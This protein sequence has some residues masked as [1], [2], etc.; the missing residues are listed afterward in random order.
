MSDRASF[1]PE[2]IIAA[3]NKAD[4][5]YVV[6]GGF[7]AELHGVP[8]PPTD[9]I[10]FTPAT[11][12]ANLDR[13]AAA[14]TGLDATLKGD[15]SPRTIVFDPDTA[16]FSQL[17]RFACRHGDFHLSFRPAGTSGFRDLMTLASARRVGAETVMVADLADVIRSKA[18]AGRGKDLMVLPVLQAV[19]DAKRPTAANLDFPTPLAGAKRPRTAPTVPQAPKRPRGPVP[20]P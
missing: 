10:D 17:W 13:V 16:D 19:H 18:A 1:D 12:R 2:A 3:L 8:L 6:I 15:P 11:D 14:I 20:R 9:N 4:V 5:A 7:A